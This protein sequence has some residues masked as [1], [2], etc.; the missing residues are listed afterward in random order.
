MTAWLQRS[1]QRRRTTPVTSESLTD[2][3]LHHV[4]SFLLQQHARTK[5][6]MLTRQLARARASQPQPT[7]GNDTAGNNRAGNIQLVHKSPSSARP[8]PQHPPCLPHHAGNATTHGNR[9]QAWWGPGTQEARHACK[10]R[11]LSGPGPRP[12]LN[13]AMRLDA[14]PTAPHHPPI[15]GSTGPLA[16]PGPAPAIPI[17]RGRNLTDVTFVTASVTD[18][19]ACEYVIGGIKDRPVTEGLGLG[20][21]FRVRVRVRG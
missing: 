12:T 3:N 9:L 18:G 8:H 11:R 6:Y 20:L 14:C 16:R 2:L 15:P 21:G 5:F 19:P 1:K 17:G 7:T 4:A 10:D 13:T